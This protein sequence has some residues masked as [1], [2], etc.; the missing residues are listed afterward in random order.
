MIARDMVLC[1][2]C[3]SRVDRLYDLPAEVTVDAGSRHTAVPL[4]AGGTRACRW[5][6][7][8]VTEG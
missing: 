2:R 8:E 1:P 6:L 5:C 7:H 4:G 3:G